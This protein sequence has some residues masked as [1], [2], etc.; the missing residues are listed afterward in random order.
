MTLTEAV[1]ILRH[2]QQ[3]QIRGIGGLHPAQITQAID[4]IIN[5]KKSEPIFDSEEEV[6]TWLYMNVPLAIE[7]T[8]KAKT[9]LVFPFTSAHAHKQVVEHL[10][11]QLYK[12]QQET[13]NQ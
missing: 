11:K 5:N 2:H 8:K 12:L 6:I 4:V 1:E 9:F 3:W 13:F 10:G 7:P